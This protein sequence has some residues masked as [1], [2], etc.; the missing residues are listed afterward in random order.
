ML[1]RDSIEMPKVYKLFHMLGISSNYK[2]YTQT[3]YAVYLAAQK[4]QRLSLVTKRLYPEVAKKYHT[5]WNAVERNIRTILTMIWN[6]NSE[7]LEKM[8]GHPLEKKPG[9]A[10][11][12]SILASALKESHSV[13]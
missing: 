12:I 7:S 6:N 9:T 13:R 10:Q 11:F 8:A 4:P 3:A 1:F 5:T 2:G